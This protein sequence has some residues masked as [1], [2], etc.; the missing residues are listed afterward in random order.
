MTKTQEVLSK[1]ASMVNTDTSYNLKE[2]QKILADAYKETGGKVK[3][4]SDVKK[5]P[6]QYNLY[7][8]KEIENIKNNGVTDE[9][10]EKL[11]ESGFE[12]ITPKV[13]M[14]VAAERWKK[15]SSAVTEE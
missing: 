4:T 1:F 13:Y 9:E 6:S 10:R 7:I 12:D 15:R 2:L 14:K 3:K 11:K 8:R 5:E